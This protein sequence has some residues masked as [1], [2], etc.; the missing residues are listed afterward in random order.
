MHLYIVRHGA[1][2]DREDPVCPPDPERYLTKE[3]IAK[4]RE[5]ARGI[6]RLGIQPDRLISSP[7]VRAMQTSSI[8]AKVFDFPTDNILTSDALLPEADPSRIFR[9][10]ENLDKSVETFCF[11]HG[12]NVDGVVARALD[13]SQPITSLKKAGIACIEL[14]RILPPAGI[15][16]WLASPK[17]L[18]SIGH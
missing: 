9:E 7:Y 4:T 10:L 17:I 18:R 15:L 3:G 6:R 11:G 12:P 5:V 16:L 13:L 14:E 8:F 2:I 1:A